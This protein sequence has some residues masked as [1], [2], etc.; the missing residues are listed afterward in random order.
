MGEQEVRLIVAE[1]LE[2]LIE[3]DPMRFMGPPG[4]DGA[5]GMDGLPGADGQPGSNGPPI[6]SESCNHCWHGK[7]LLAE[8]RCDKYVCCKC[9]GHRW[10]G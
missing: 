10:E 5:R 2:K 4:P 7:D 1:E 3:A 6:P 8:V 9:S